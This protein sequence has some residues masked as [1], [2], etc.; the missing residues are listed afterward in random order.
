MNL[1]DLIQ[2]DGGTLKKQATTGNGIAPFVMKPKIVLIGARNGC[3]GFCLF[4]NPV[5]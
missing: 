2:A 5:L 1:L 3:P 4:V